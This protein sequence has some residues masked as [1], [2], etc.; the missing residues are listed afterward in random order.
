VTVTFVP[1]ATVVAFTD[2]VGGGTIVKSSDDDVPPPGGGVETETSADP[3]EATSLAAIAAV[4]CVLLTNVVGRALPFQFTTD[5]D[6]KPDPLTASVKPAAPATP[7]EGAS[8]FTAGTGG[9][10]K[11]TVTAGLVAARVEPLLRKR[12][13]SYVPAVDGAATV[14]VRV[15][16]PLPT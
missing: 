16:T 8:E 6:A 15:V 14:H 9:G 5:E 3:T 11:T 12:R 13:N 10:T 1:D 2:R 7:L 4:N